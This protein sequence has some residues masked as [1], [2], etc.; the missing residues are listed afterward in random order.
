MNRVLLFGL[1][2][3]LG[4]IF[5]CHYIIGNTRLNFSQIDI[6]K[7]LSHNNVTAIV[8][9]SKGFMWFGTRDGLNRY[10]GYT[11]RKYY[12]NPNYSN[13]LWG[14][15]INS[16]HID[17]KGNLWVCTQNGLNIY[18]R[19]KDYFSRI[20]IP[21]IFK[22][23]TNIIYRIVEYGEGSYIICSEEG[24]FIFE[25]KESN[26]IPE[27]N[28]KLLAPNI[29]TRCAYVDS[30]KKIWLGSNQGLIE[31]D[32]NLKVLNIISPFG[33]KSIYNEVFSI[34]SFGD[35][36]IWFGTSDGIGCYSKKDGKMSFLKHT[37]DENSLIHNSINPL[38]G[39]KSG[40]L[41]IGTQKGLDI[42]NTHKKQFTHYAQDI[43]NPGSLSHN[44]V[45]SVFIDENF[46]WVG[47]YA[48]G[49]NMASFK[50]PN[51]RSY[52][53]NILD[54]NSLS[55]NL[56]NALVAD[57]Y[58]IWIGTDG[59]G[60][61][62]FNPENNNFI[63]FNTSNSQLSDDV[64]LTLLIDR[65]DNLW[66][67]TF[68]NGITVYNLKKKTYKHLKYSDSNL[69]TIR[70][71]QVWAL[72]E[73]RDGYIWMGLWGGLEKYDPRTGKFIHFQNEQDNPTSLSGFGVLS[74]KQDS[75]GNIWVGT[76]NEG[77]NLCRPQTNSFTR[78]MID[79]K[80]SSPANAINCIFEDSDKNLW[81]GTQAGLQ[82]IEYKN[83]AFKIYGVNN[84]L[85][86]S[87]IQGIQEDSKNQLWVS[88]NTGLY[89]FD[90][91]KNTLL[92]FD[93]TDGIQSNQFSRNACY[94]SLNGNLIFGGVNGFTFF[95]PAKLQPYQ[96]VPK[97]CFTN[98]E[99]HNKPVVIAENSP[100]QKAIDETE[101]IT[102]RHDESNFSI[103]FSALTYYNP[104]K[105][106]YIYKLEG[107]DKNWNYIKNQRKISFSNLAHGSYKL[108]VKSSNRENVWDLNERS[109]VIT[110]LPPWWKQWWAKTIYIIILLLI[111]Y[112]FIHFILLHQKDLH[113][114]EIEKIEKE[115]N[116]KINQSKMQFFIN[117]SHEIR[118]PLT[119]IIDPIDQLLKQE[120]G[121][122]RNFQLLSIMKR[123][124]RYLLNM[125]KQLLDFNK[126]ENK[127]L[128]LKNSKCN[129]NTFL[130]EI[131]Q[132]FS[133]LSKEKK[134]AIK[135][136]F[137][138]NNIETYIDVEKF[139]TICNNLIFNAFK[140]MGH[141]NL[142]TLQVNLLASESKFEVLF[143]DNGK[144]IDPNELEKIFD[145]FY[146]ASVDQN[147]GGTGIGLS[148]TKSLAELMNGQVAV[149]SQ[150]NS[151][152]TFKV[153]LPYIKVE[154]E[155][156]TNTS[157]F[158]TENVIEADE[159]PQLK[160]ASESNTILV[161]DDSSDVR[162]YIITNFKTRFKFIEAENGL[163][164]IKLA[165]DCLPDLIISD[166]M[167]PQMDGIEFVR[168]IKGNILT[169]HIPVL[170]LTAKSDMP[171]K[172]K[173]YEFG[174]D[175][176]VEKPFSIV[177]L[178]T[179]SISLINNRIALKKAYLEKSGESTGK[180]IS[181]T[182]DEQFLNKIMD[183]IEK[184]L[185]RSDLE[186]SNLCSEL[187]MSSSNLYRKIKAVTDLS[188]ND[189]IKDYR[190]KRA[191][192]ML[193]NGE[194]SV[195]EVAYK[196]GFS[197]PLYFSKCFKKQYG[198]SPS[199]FIERL[200]SD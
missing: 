114:L 8:K 10:D 62:Y 129:L 78:I 149:E 102:L 71:N 103:E 41:Y 134:I 170:L 188:P 31:V 162:K 133:H 46:L 153:T 139:E 82:R 23:R 58:G 152:T 157:S 127:N 131:S 40:N 95:N 116:E 183:Y 14:S 107:V 160:V 52:N 185:S 161:V 22:K 136:I 67:G 16:L 120:N 11:I 1:I 7:G 91:Q 29:Q 47:T 73:D 20:V 24:S 106:Q 72:L 9:D 77:L 59:G 55:N 145:R 21:D 154:Y 180:L 121:N 169:S 56:V 108:I 49:V 138:H 119:L 159:E 42:Y 85:S 113:N 18:D 38:I 26:I 81:I 101:S 84:E 158:S 194:T 32:N 141:G 179:Q 191:G 61:D 12:S 60:I 193:R 54:K 74:L 187:G 186:I 151:G 45:W 177:L 190:M 197:D 165:N 33:N 90:R 155:N 13:S 68:Y 195:A 128:V 98:F 39:D 27:E 35:N 181:N 97:L 175:A 172:L 53:R 80:G 109:L 96:E 143:K 28:I 100:L 196:T 184:E 117:I 25:Y 176:Y 44:S 87:A 182:L 147:I 104:S 156:L 94:K 144:G 118:T 126:L 111:I 142:I 198:V 189:F 125:T 115:N 174:A 124:A 66:I 50:E 19:N 92:K 83:G 112:S 2:L 88:T 86:G 37:S 65:N 93:H 69:N 148:L 89:Q 63:N 122:S 192:E 64:I 135:L 137:S 110:V 146:Q 173:G 6:N 48:G 200:K 3:I 163:E 140:Y 150:T 105:N 166:I 178:E 199:T 5:S 30:E 168:K 76:F 79:K 70:K 17:K 132:N 34:Y 167:M 99:I 36:N 43:K 164:A 75:K 171:S 4:D 123:N 51:F 15:N 130:F 57:Q